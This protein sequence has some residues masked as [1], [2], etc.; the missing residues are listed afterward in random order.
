MKLAQVNLKMS[1]A[2]RNLIVA[3]GLICILV[4]FSLLLY[5][6]NKHEVPILRTTI[7]S[8]CPL[9]RM[10]CKI[11][12]PGGQTLE[13]DIAPKGLPVMEPLMLNVKGV[14]NDN[15]SMVAWFEGKSMN[16]GKHYM[17]P[18]TIKSQLPDQ[19]VLQ[20]MIPVCSIDKEMVWLLNVDIPIQNQIYNIQF[21]LKPMSGD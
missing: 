6:N 20:G 12:M 18:A 11:F 21:Q 15:N 9:E 8:L 17:F 14:G 4:F 2:V 19:K 1:L 10:P 13:F 7:L 16:M 5:K 3:S